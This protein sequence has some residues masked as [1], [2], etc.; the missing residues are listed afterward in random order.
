MCVKGQNNDVNGSIDCWLMCL[1][2]V[3]VCKGQKNDIYDSID[4]C[5]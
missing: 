1:G 5:V 3:G 2:N 4:R